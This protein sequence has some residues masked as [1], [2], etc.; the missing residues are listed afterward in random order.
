VAFGRRGRGAAKGADVAY[1]L[2]VPFEDAA[3]VKE[4][5]VQL[6]SGKTLG[7]QAAARR[8]GRAKIRLAGSGR[9]GPGGN[10]D[11]IISIAIRPHPFFTREGDAVRLD[12]PDQPRRGG[13]RRQGEGADGRTGR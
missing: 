10:G 9:A 5:R 11:A 4:Q 3:L 7:H 8:R 12:L 1:R 13:A 2:D 6:R